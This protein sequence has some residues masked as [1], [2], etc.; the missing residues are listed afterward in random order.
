VARLLHAAPVLYQDVVHVCAG[1]QHV[2][3]HPHV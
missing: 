3:P 2:G 1:R